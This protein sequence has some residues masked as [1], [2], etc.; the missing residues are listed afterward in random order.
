MRLLETAAVLDF[1]VEAAGAFFFSGE[2]DFLDFSGETD[3]LDFSGETD[4]LDSGAF[5]TGYCS[6]L[7]EVDLRGRYFSAV[8]FLAGE[9][10]LFGAALEDTTGAAFGYT[11]LIVTAFATDLERVA[12]FLGATEAERLALAILASALRAAFWSRLRRGADLTG[13]LLLERA[14]AATFLTC[15]LGDSLRLGATETLL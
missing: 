15:F 10:L 6:F 8:G 11:T 5:F 9:V 12:N 4:F 3:F 14:G 7:I 2:I 1:L 13:L